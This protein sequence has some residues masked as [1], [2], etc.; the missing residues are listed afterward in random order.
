MVRYG[1]VC[2]VM[3]WYGVVRYGTVRYGMVWYGVF[4]MHQYNHLPE[5]ETSVTKCVEDIK[6]LKTI[7]LI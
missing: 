7:K 6:K 5:D 2:Y 4:Y 1:M 3:L